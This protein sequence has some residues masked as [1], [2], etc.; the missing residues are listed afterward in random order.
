MNKNIANLYQMAAKSSRRIIGLMSGTSLDGLDIALCEVT[1]TG[2]DTCVALIEFT[3]VP[4][5]GDV[6]HRIR[7]VF[8]KDVVPFPY[9]ILLNGWIGE[10][11]AHMVLGALEKWGIAA[12]TVDLVASHGQTV[13]HCPKSLHMLPDFSITCTRDRDRRPSSVPL[14]PPDRA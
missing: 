2:T 9:L 3:T 1:G 7:E 6:K 12:A 10:L 4:Y 11:H 14:D 13:M 8:A 5:S